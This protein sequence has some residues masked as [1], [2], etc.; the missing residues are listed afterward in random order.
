MATG[1]VVSTTTGSTETAKEFGELGHGVFSYSLLEALK[2]KAANNKMITIVVQDKFK[3]ENKF[4]FFGT[5]NC[6]AEPLLPTQFFRENN[7]FL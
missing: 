3:Y 1:S 6:V 2:G 7:R 4:V 5:N